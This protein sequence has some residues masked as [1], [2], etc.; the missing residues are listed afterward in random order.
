MDQNNLFNNSFEVYNTNLT[1]N[2]INTELNFKTEVLKWLNDGRYKYFKS[3][4]EGSYKV[5]LMNISLSPNDQ[6]SRMIHTFSATAYEAGSIEDY[7][8]KINEK[9][10][11][12]STEQVIRFTY[13][14]DNKYT[15][16]N[17]IVIGEEYDNQIFTSIG[18]T[19]IPINCDYMEVEF[20]NS[21][22]EILDNGTQKY[23]ITQA[24]FW[25]S[26]ELQGLKFIN[27]I[28]PSN[29][30][31]LSNIQVNF[32]CKISNETNG[33][34]ETSQ[35]NVPR[36]GTFTATSTIDSPLYYYQLQALDKGNNSLTLEQKINSTSEALGANILRITDSSFNTKDFVVMNQLLLED[37]IAYKVEFGANLDITCTVYGDLGGVS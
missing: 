7:K 20:L 12:S 13:N 19:G 36:V 29:S 25:Y 10:I 34:N 5:R 15:K 26:G 37:F 22:R 16:D 21:K 28:N 14:F 1:D 2:N 31:D 33:A 27:F 6:L 4:T 9:I 8:Y 18:I 32:E 24:G 3:P 23:Y 11:N 35:I 30:L 17:A